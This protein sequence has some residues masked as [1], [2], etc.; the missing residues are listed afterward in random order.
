MSFKQKNK[1]IT[2]AIESL[3]VR[4]PGFSHYTNPEG[5]T[6][7]VEIPGTVPGDIVQASLQR[8]KR[9]LIVASLVQVMTPSKDRVQAPCPHF[10]VCGGCKWQSISYEAQ[11]AEKERRV[12]ALFPTDASV[13]PILPSPSTYHYR[14]KMEFSFSQNKAGERFLG[15]IREGSKGRVENL[16][17]CLLVDPWV[18]STLDVVRKWWIEVGLEA[19]YPPKDEGTLKTLTLRHGVRTGDKMVILGVSGNPQA[20]L[21]QDQLS[22]FKEKIQNHL[23]QDVSLFLKV[24]Q[25]IKGQ[26]TQIYEML[27]GGKDH[28]HEELHLFGQVIRIKISP[29]AFFQPNTLQA[30][31]LYAQAVSMADLKGNE[32]VYDL[33]SGTGTLGLLA[34]LKS[35]EVVSVEIVPDAV[36]DARENAIANQRNNITCLKGDVAEVIDELIEKK[37]PSPDLVFVDPPRAGLGLK[38]LH[39]ILRLSPRRIIYIS[40]QPLSQIEDIKNLPG[41]TIRAIQPVDQFPQ[42]PHIENIVRL[43]RDEI[44]S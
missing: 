25:A 13:F 35:K 43:D 41:Y 44:S 39:Q 9:K 30:E 1:E 34:S 42:T 12:R 27:L 5:H 38:A 20:A 14:N 22:L 11:L 21:T 31:R 33:Y 8:R 6:S 19:Y 24:Y 36:Y 16:S 32:V 28:I 18:A 7:K 3:S 10:L 2:L 26:P 40:C 15:L 37:S 17:V 29:H 4:G 23:G